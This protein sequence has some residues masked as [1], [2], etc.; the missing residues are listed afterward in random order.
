[1]MQECEAD[2]EELQIP[3]LSFSG[4]M[5]V[6]VIHALL[7]SLFTIFS[8]MVRLEIKPGI[9]VPKEGHAAKGA[10]SGL[11]GMRAEGV[12]G[13]VALSLTLPTI[14]EISRSM[15]GD[16]IASVGNDAVDLAGELANML[17]GGAKRILSER[18]HD[19]DMQTPQLLLGEGHEIVHHYSGQTVLLPINIGPDEFYIELNFILAIE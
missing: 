9:P 13:S 4:Q 14:R 19:F 15:L 2:K 17:V 6:V 8:T 16:E 10:V 5:D 12:S 11:I 18:G 7:E 1:M 3:V